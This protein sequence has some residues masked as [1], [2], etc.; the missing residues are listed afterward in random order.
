MTNE[1]HTERLNGIV[2]KARALDFSFIKTIWKGR[3]KRPIKAKWISLVSD[4]GN[5]PAPEKDE[6]P[7]FNQCSLYLETASCQ[8]YFNPEC[9]VVF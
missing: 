8:N 4:S 9:A 3:I 2:N 1:Q 6:N 7:Q 5:D